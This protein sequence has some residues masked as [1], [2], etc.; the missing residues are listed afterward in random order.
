MEGVGFAGVFGGRGAEGGGQLRVWAE[1]GGG[2]WGRCVVGVF[3]G[4]GV[5][6]T[7]AEEL[8][9]VDSCLLNMLL[10]SGGHEH[11]VVRCSLPSRPSPLS[12][13]QTAAETPPARSGSS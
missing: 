12:I 9:A 4:G 13:V 7:A 3:G 1:G 6:G 10:D 2:I 5:V 11:R 8:S